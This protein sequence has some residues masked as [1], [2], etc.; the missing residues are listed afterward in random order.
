[1]PLRI[2]EGQTEALKDVVRLTPDQWSRMLGSLR[3]APPTLDMDKLATNLGDAINSSAV[4]GV[5]A[6]LCL[7]RDRADASLDDFI[8]EFIDTVRSEG[9]EPAIGWQQFGDNLKSALLMP[10]LVIAAKAFDIMTE[11]ANVYWSARLV[12]D[13]RAIFAPALD[14]DPPKAA[15]LVHTLKIRYHTASGPNEFFVAMDSQDVHGLMKVLHRAREKERGL[16][17]MMNKS[18]TSCL[19]PEAGE[20]Q[21]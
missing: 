6:G 13:V 9:M 4:L 20:E 2:P 10:S 19:S 17:A 18:G 7:T 12:T 8:R 16:R 5:L 14:A 21:A 11:H 1:M 3:E 15:V